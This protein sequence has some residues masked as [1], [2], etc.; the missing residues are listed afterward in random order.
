MANSIN[1]PEPTD[2]SS[3]EIQT[4]IAEQW[5]EE[6]GD[7]LFKFA[8]LRV[9]SVHAAEDLLQETF[10]KAIKAYPKFRHEA[11]VRTWLFQIMRNEVNGY[12]RKQATRKKREFVEE[13]AG[14]SELLHPKITKKEFGTGLE[15]EE[16]WAVIQT[17]F[18]KIP[19]HLL[20]TFLFRIA[21]PDRKIENLCNEL[22]VK[23]SNFSVRMFR[24]RLL[25]RKCLEQNW[26][27]A[28]E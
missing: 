21:N 15:K 28:N 16:F 3:K 4:G 7:I 2:S 26:F 13:E 20:E 11:S 14:I 25:L 17:C 10:F 1:S 8:S 23:P 24:T 12:L 19:E 22:D 9:K 18:E 6:H 5:M 27:K